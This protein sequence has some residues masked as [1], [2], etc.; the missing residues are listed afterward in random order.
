VA[1]FRILLLALLAAAPVR[2]QE[3]PVEYQVKA[4]YLYNF[5]RFVEWP[6]RVLTERLNICVA[7]PSPFGDVLSNTVRDET[8]GGRQVA[9]REIGDP[10]GSCQ[11]LF[12]PRDAPADI[13]LRTARGT[14]TLT[15]GESPTFIRQGGIV[16]FIREGANV[17]FEID[18]EA[19]RRAGLRI[20]SR[21]LRLARPPNG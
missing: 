4:A 19:A 10:D 7:R 8:V 12:I 18:E 17:R 9:A 14:P 6:A 1:R 11:V 21:L 15:V 13:Y 16:N 20:S 3:V 5:A 2:T